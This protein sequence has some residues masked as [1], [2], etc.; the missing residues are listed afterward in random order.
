MDAETFLLCLSEG[1]EPWEAVAAR[2]RL[3]VDRAR[4][5]ARALG[6]AG[7]PVLLEES[8][9]GLAPD[10]LAPQHV[11]PRLKG[12]FGRPYRYLGTVTSTQ[13]VLR[14][15]HEAPEGALVVAEHQT[16]GRGRLGRPWLS[17][18]GNLCFSLLLRRPQP[19]LLPLRVGVA[20]AQAAGFGLLKWPNDLLS[21]DGRKLGGILIECEGGRTFVG[22]GVN[23]V[24]APLP[25]AAALKEF[26]AV[27]RV[28]LLVAF[29]ALLEEW[30]AQPPSA[31]LQAWQKWDGTLG[32]EVRVHTPTGVVEGV[33]EAIS[34]E[35]A[36]LVRTNAGRKSVRVG[37]VVLPPPPNV[38]EAQEGQGQAQGRGASEG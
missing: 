38:V 3:S 34:Q 36:L 27:N 33:A 21:P 29:L 11:L 30:L 14:A 23:V 35:G 18:P 26:R 20:L 37:E 1:L 5:F 15:W 10:S 7:Y 6:E 22:V 28:D 8:G 12:R 32:R 16:R 31:V 25:T 17:S 19:P 2:A 24:Q 9:V 13:D 4:L